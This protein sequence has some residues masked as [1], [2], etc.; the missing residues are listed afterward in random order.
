MKNTA[1][2]FMYRVPVVCWVVCCCL[3]KQI[4]KKVDLTKACPNATSVF[5]LY[6]ANLFPIIFKKPSGSNYQKQLEG[7]PSGCLGHMESEGVFNKRGFQQVMVNETTIDPFLHVNILRKLEGQGDHCD[8]L[9]YL[10]G[11]LWCLVYVLLFPQRV[12]Y[13]HRLS[14]IN[15]QDLITLSRERK[16]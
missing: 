2:L 4:W 8:G 10:P 15:I 12:M 13:Y 3:R 1:L 14:L 11:M 7:V 5:V 16:L 6:L 9:V